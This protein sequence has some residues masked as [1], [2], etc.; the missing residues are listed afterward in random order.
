MSSRN[1][2]SRNSRHERRT[3]IGYWHDQSKDHPFPHPQSL[4]DRTWE[5]ARRAR[6]VD[7]LKAGETYGWSPGH[8]Y[9]RFCCLLETSHDGTIEIKARDR[10]R[11]ARTESGEI[12]FPFD[13]TLNGL[14]TCGDDRWCWPSGLAHYVEAHAIRLPDE[15]VAHAAARQFQPDDFML[16]AAK[17]PRVTPAT[18]LTLDYRFWWDWSERNAHFQFEPNCLACARG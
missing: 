15:F 7:Y 14:E 2:R 13:P 10:L 16:R 3:V 11:V 18:R 5:T 9:C 8:S 4:V 6:I 1:S 17:A 12:V